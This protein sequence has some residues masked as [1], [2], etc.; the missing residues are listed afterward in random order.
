MP[1]WHG[2]QKNRDLSGRLARWSLKLQHYDFS[3]E[4][5]KAEKNVVPDALSRQYMDEISYSDMTC[6]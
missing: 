4:Y 5:R 1:V 2:S 6:N 3:V